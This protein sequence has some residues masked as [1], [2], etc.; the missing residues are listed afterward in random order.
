MA[1]DLGTGG[2]D[3]P[4]GE[5]T[6]GELGR[7]LEEHESRNATDIETL[8]EEVRWT[9]RLLLGTLGAA[10]LASVLSSAVGIVR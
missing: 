5:W 4:N 2:V 7:R 10:L 3:V 6:L 1:L 8:R 9:R